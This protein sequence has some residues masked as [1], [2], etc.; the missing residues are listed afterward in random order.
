MRVCPW[1]STQ[2][3]LR[4]MSKIQTELDSSLFHKSLDF[5]AFQVGFTK[6]CVYDHLT[7][8]VTFVLSSKSTSAFR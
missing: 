3:V 5:S 6:T 7:E 4:E 2:S 8:N 1:Q